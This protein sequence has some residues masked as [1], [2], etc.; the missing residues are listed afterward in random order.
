MLGLAVTRRPWRKTPKG[1]RP[2]CRQRRPICVSR[3]PL[4]P[5]LAEK[6]PGDLAASP[7]DLRDRALSDNRA[8]ETTTVPSSNAAD[9][10]TS[11]S[12]F[13]RYPVEAED[14]LQGTTEPATGVVSES[15]GSNQTVPA[16]AVPSQTQ[17]H[18]ILWDSFPRDRSG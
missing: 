18:V 13:I 2:S 5:K 12:G 3:L 8:S 16:I 4:V 1:S 11:S 14:G 9:E 10:N 17:I 6:R 15:C 7:G